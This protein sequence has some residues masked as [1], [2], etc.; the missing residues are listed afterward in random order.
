MLYEPQR[1]I[2]G[3]LYTSLDMDVDVP[4]DATVSGNIE[5]LNMLSII[6]KKKPPRATSEDVKRRS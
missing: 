3:S 6:V 2:S 1:F 5:L 4:K